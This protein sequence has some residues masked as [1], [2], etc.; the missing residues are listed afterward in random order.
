M[1]NDFWVTRDAIY[2]QF[3]LMTSSLVKIIDKSPH[4]SP[5]NSQ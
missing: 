1:N 5:K 3:S 2:Q 4:S